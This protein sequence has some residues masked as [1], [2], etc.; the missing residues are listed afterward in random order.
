VP[1]DDRRGPDRRELR[2]D[3]RLLAWGTCAPAN[4]SYTPLHQGPRAHGVAE[5]TFDQR[6]FT[7]RGKAFT[8]LSVSFR[9]RLARASS[10]SVLVHHASPSQPRLSHEPPSR[11]TKVDIGSRTGWNPRS[12]HLDRPR[13]IA[14]G[15]HRGFVPTARRPMTAR[16]WPENIQRTQRPCPRRLVVDEKWTGAAPLIE[17]MFRPITCPS[18]PSSFGA[19]RPDGPHVEPNRRAVP[20]GSGAVA[21]APALV[22]MQALP[23]PAPEVP[24]GAMACRPNRVLA[25]RPATMRRGLCCHCLATTI[26]SPGGTA[27]RS[28]WSTTY[29][30]SVSRVAL[31]NPYLIK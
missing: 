19:V 14:A 17:G 7:N 26:L 29:S 20:D 8:S 24:M 13:T 3:Q 10:S 16:W 4:S 28:R 18:L 30:E 21:C 1:L 12:V 15:L 2:V 22:Q 31:S 23:V 25:S 11:V 9:G 5:R 6:L 27:V